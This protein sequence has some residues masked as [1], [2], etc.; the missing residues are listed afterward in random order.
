MT[1]E[2]GRRRLRHGQP[3]LSI[4]GHTSME[5]T[6]EYTIVRSRR[7]TM[8]LQVREDGQVLVR[9][10]LWATDRQAADFAA[11]HKRWLEKRKREARKR[12]A[13]RQVI[14]AE[15]A[16]RLRRQARQVLAEKTEYWAR[17]MGVSYGRISIRQQATR[18]GSCSAAGNLNYNWQLVLLPEP[19]QDYVVV[20]ELAHRREMNH[21]PR[22][23]A[24]VAAYLPD[25]RERKKALRQWEHRVEVRQEP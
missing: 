16:S 25:C 14:G 1:S 2:A 24:V 23:W 22:F 3:P 9:C 12:A 7:K 18:W 5:Q 13:G 17:R 21:S 11:K 20:H 4:G 8:E 6:A 19:L 15:E 10:P